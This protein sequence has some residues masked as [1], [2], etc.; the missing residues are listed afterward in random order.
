MRSTAHVRSLCLV[1]VEL[2]SSVAEEFK[3][4]S[5]DENDLALITVLSPQFEGQVDHR[6]QT[7]LAYALERPCYGLHNILPSKI[8]LL[9]QLENSKIAKYHKNV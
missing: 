9:R 3:A 7:L 4:V 6:P 1:Q 5:H 8:D 2:P